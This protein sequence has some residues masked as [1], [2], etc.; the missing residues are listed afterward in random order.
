MQVQ[1]D[2]ANPKRQGASKNFSALKRDNNRCSA[3]ANEADLYEVK[4]QD[5]SR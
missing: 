2:L 3:A 1:P 4:W 5:V